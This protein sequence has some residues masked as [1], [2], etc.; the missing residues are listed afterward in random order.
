MGGK[1]TAL[2]HALAAVAV[3][4][5]AGAALLQ[6]ASLVARSEA[7][8]RCVRAAGGAVRRDQL[9]RVASVGY[10]GDIVNGELG[11]AIRVAALRRVGCSRADAHHR[12]A[13]RP[14][15][16]GAGGAC[17]LHLRWPARPAVVASHR[18][19]CGHARP[20]GL[21]GRLALW[22]GL[23]GWWRGLSVLHDPAQRARRPA[24]SCSRHNGL[25]ASAN[26]ANR[27]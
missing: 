24:S 5:I 15:R 1:W 7:S 22:G 12:G 9:Y 14:R 27:R 26:G 6:L 3:V 8:H 18:L 25:P 17:H 11:F 13:D 10:L 19:V 4:T 21:L 20:R 2:T 23:A 16:G